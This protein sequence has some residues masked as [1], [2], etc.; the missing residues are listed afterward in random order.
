MRPASFAAV[1]LA[2]L[3]ITAHACD[4]ENGLAERLEDAHERWR[5]NGPPDYEM[6]LFR[7]CFCPEDGR[8]PVVV[9]VVDGRVESRVYVEGAGDVREDLEPYFPDVEGL[10]EIAAEAARDADRVEAE[11]HAELGHPVQLTIDW[12]EQMA[13]EEV[14]Y[15]VQRLTPLPDPPME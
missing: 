15:R 11:F 4:D 8:G 1:A 12:E 10:F 6:V 9:T 7:G 14:D 2:A 5:E 3:L 13:D